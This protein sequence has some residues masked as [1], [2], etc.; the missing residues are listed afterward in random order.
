MVVESDIAVLSIAPRSRRDTVSAGIT[1][2]RTDSAVI[3]LPGLSGSRTAWT[4]A[5]SKANWLTVT[6]AA[7]TGSGLT[8]WKRNPA[9][10]NAGV[11]VDT[12]TINAGTS[13]GSPGSIVDSLV[14]LPRLTLAA[15]SRRDTLLS[16]SSG[17]SAVTRQ[18]SIGGDPEGAVTWTV[19][20]G[21]AAWLTLTTTSGR[22]NGP[23]SWTRSAANLRDGIF[24]DTITVSAGQARLQ[25][26]DTLF[27]SA[28]VVASQCAADHIF[29]NACLDAAQLRWLDLAGN[30]DG[31]Y[32]LGDLIAFL[33][34]ANAPAAFRPRRR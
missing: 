22:G 29:G 10:L 15:A 12:I 31:Q 3:S 19:S 23:I 13:V 34:R 25:A 8:R 11:Y 24:V 7:G 5:A 2:L 27:V 30:R 32:N 9:G 14:I 17:T 20:H 21:A 4:A 28:P 18:L 1:T 6:T 33:T 26:L 16:G